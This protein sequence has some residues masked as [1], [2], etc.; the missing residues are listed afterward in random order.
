MAI[1]YCTGHCTG[2]EKVWIATGVSFTI[3]I[4]ATLGTASYIFSY[5]YFSSYL[6]LFQEKS[7]H[8]CE[9]DRLQYKCSFSGYIF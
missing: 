3:A 2:S 8:H 1:R 7:C 9:I 4:M 6:Y 5:L